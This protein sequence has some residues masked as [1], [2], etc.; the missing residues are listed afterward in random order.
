MQ[1]FVVFCLILFL[2]GFI[3]SSQLSG[4]VISDPESEYSRIRK[5]AFSGKL[6]EAEASAKILVDSFP[7]YGDAQILLARIYAWQNKFQPSIT[8]LDSLLIHEPGNSDAIEARNIISGWIAAENLTMEEKRKSKSQFF[9]DKKQGSTDIRTGYSF[10]S[11]TRPYNHFWQVFKAGA[12]HQFKWGPASASLNLG[13]IKIGD[14][15]PRSATEPQIEFDAYP[16]LT[17]KNY[18]YFD[19][20][21]SPGS[22]F[23]KHRSALELWQVLPDGWAI[24]AGLNY[25]YFNRNI[26]IGLASVEKYIGNYWLSA[27]TFVYFKDEGTTTSFYVNAR[28]YFNTGDF[29]QVTVGTGTAPDEPFDIQTDLM[30]LSAYSISLAYNVSLNSKLRM[31]IGTGYSREEFAESEW[32]NRFEGGVNFAY[33]LKMK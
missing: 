23:P 27:K 5:L 17:K 9:P 7:S 30:R 25:Y 4:Q 19:Y 21:F 10:D 13:N 1:K 18:A 8:I 33:D 6:T 24:S 28:Q 3:L 14:P 29:I 32:R 15:S 26:F 22:Y 16:L 11:F 12:G 2:A 20:A 31:R